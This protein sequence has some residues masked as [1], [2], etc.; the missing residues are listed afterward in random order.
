MEVFLV[1]NRWQGEN[2][3]KHVYHACCQTAQIQNKHMSL[4]VF[5]YQKPKE[6]WVFD[7][8]SARKMS[9]ITSILRYICCN[10]VVIGGYNSLW[11]WASLVLSKLLFKKVILWTGASYQSTLNHTLIH[12]ALKYLFISLA[13]KY[14]V[15]G[16]LAKKY[17]LRYN[18][19]KQDIFV[20]PN[21][22]CIESKEVIETLLNKRFEKGIKKPTFGFV[23]RICKQKGFIEFV[24]LANL[25]QDSGYKFQAFG[26]I[27]KGDEEINKALIGSNVEYMGSVESEQM[28]NI[29]TNIDALIHPT[30]F[31]PFSRI[32]SEALYC[33]TYVICSFYDDAHIDLITPNIGVVIDGKNL[34]HITN[35]VN[36]L[37]STNNWYNRNERLNRVNY[38]WRKYPSN[39]YGEALFNAIKG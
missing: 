24:K 9:I 17:L 34:L 23:G 7:A 32:T 10:A 14:L 18:V 26:K 27:D 39:V 16:S 6:L 22:S 2:T 5:Q 29:L 13:D 8:N 30:H 38:F 3:R 19:K 25:F 12:E 20:G 11:C 37:I 35:C 28:A 31:D 15:Y 1:T 21:L 33:G 36:H 4:S